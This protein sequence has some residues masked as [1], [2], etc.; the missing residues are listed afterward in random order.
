MNRMC[1]NKDFPG[2][3]FTA[4]EMKIL[5]IIESQ[6]LSPVVMGFS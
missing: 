4:T 2:E 1:M 3:Y 5:A 6:S